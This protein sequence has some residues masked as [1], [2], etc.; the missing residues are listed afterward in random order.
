[1]TRTATAARPRWTRFAPGFYDLAVPGNPG[2]ATVRRI[3]DLA[4]C[5][6]DKWEVTVIVDG[7]RIYD[8]LNFPTMAKAKA[9][10]ESDVI[11]RIWE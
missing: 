11:A 6:C 7:Y 1:M 2:T 10:A 5:T 4:G 8:G 3:C 9:W